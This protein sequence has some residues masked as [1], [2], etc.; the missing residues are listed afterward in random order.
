MVR[1]PASHGGHRRLNS[2]E[3]DDWTDDPDEEDP[4]LS[5]ELEE[6]DA[7]K[8]R[9]GAGRNSRRRGDYGATPRDMDS[10]SHYSSR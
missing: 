10:S 7:T 4:L 1:P 9:S 6:D 8:K 5:K 2:I 3:N